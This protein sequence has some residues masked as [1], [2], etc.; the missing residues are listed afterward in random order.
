MYYSLC[1]SSIVVIPLIWWDNNNCVYFSFI[2]YDFLQFNLSKIFYNYLGQEIKLYT[3]D[4]LN[5]L[6]RIMNQSMAFQGVESTKQ[7]RELC[8]VSLRQIQTSFFTFPNNLQY[9]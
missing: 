4:Q 1:V 7:E 3:K 2:I 5:S 9:F 8:D 6:V